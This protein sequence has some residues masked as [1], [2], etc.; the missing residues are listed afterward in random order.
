[1]TRSQT[2]AKAEK[3]ALQGSHESQDSQAILEAYKAEFGVGTLRSSP[4]PGSFPQKSNALFTVVQTPIESSGITL[5]PEQHGEVEVAATDG[6]D[7]LPPSTRP[8]PAAE[9]RSRSAALGQ[10][11]GV[12]LTPQ[13]KQRRL[14]LQEAADDGADINIP[15]NQADSNS[16]EHRELSGPCAPCDAVHIV[17]E[18]VFTRV[19][20]GNP[21]TATAQDEDDAPE[22]PSDVPRPRPIAALA[23]TKKMDFSQQTPTQVN[24]DRDYSE[25]IDLVP[26][27]PIHEHT[28]T[29]SNERTLQ[30]NDT[31]AVDFGLS[32]LAR[33]SSQISEDAGFENTRGDWRVP[34]GTSQQHSSNAYT[35]HRRHGAA[36]ETPALPR[37]PFATTKTT[38]AA[39]LAGSQLFGQT[40]FS[41]AIKKISPT[42]S[43]PSP[44]IF[45]H[46]ISP[47]IAETS[48]LKNRANVSS[49][50]DI[51]TSSPQRL[52]EVL[53]TSS[54][55]RDA[56][57]GEE[58]KTPLNSRSTGVDVIPESPPSSGR[59][60]RAPAPRSSG[61]N[62]PLAHYEPMKKSQERKT[63]G[64]SLVLN[65]E[66]DSDDDDAVRRMERRKQVDRRRAKAAEEMERVSFLPKARQDSSDPPR[67][68]RR[69]VMSDVT[70][71]A[72]RN[73]FDLSKAESIPP[74]VGDSQKGL[75]PSNETLPETLSVQSTKATP[76]DSADAT[77]EVD[78]EGDITMEV[79]LA[80][81]HVEEE[82]I[83]AT[84][85][86]PSLP[87]TATPDEPPVEEPELPS[88]IMEEEEPG[89]SLTK[90]SEPSS[91]PLVRRKNA[92]TYGRAS[93]QRRLKPF[94]SSSYSDIVS[95]EGASKSD[96][97]SSPLRETVAVPAYQEQSAEGVPSQGK[98]DEHGQ[99]STPQG[100][101]AS[102]RSS[103]PELPPPMTTRSRRNEASPTTPLIT[104]SHGP[105]I[106]TS[107]SLSILSTTPN[108]SAKTTPGTQASPVSERPESVNLPSPG[109]GKG[110]RKRA[111]R[112]GAKSESP[113]PVTRAARMA[114]RAP[115]LGSDSTD[116]LHHSPSASALEKSMV[117]SKASRS[118]RQSL[119]PALRTCRLFEGMVFAIS[120]QNR[121]KPLERTKLETKI[122]QAG[123]TILGEGFQEMF[124]H[125]PIMSTA[126]PVIDQEDALQLTK[127]SAQCGFTAL[128]ADSHSRKAKY[129][130]ALAL[131]LPCLAHQWITACLT[132]A[133]IVD[134]QP[135]VLC[136]G[137]S[138]VLGNAIRSRTLP[139]YSAADARL[140]EVIDQRPRLLDGQRVLVVVDSR[141]ARSEAKEPYIFLATVL[142][143]SISRVFSTQQA[144][145]ALLRHQE[146]GSP[147]D[148]LYIDKGTG[149]VEAVLTPPA[150][151]PAG[152]AKKR[153]RT[154]AAQPEPTMG[155]IRVLDDEL[156][157]QSLIL[158]RMVE[159][160]EMVF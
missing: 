52:H 140:A 120:F 57:L 67:R 125:S 37:N 50:T 141:K 51:R 124:E 88:L 6:A 84:S 77:E 8:S 30:H 22:R 20:H 138:A 86:V 155:N 81:A 147:F 119:A 56:E 150:T 145:E 108:L 97:V 136:A 146:A 36:F 32:E 74:I 21:R 14:Q 113:Q 71:N 160:D 114:R 96:R 76:G 102:P 157:I 92:K 41:S 73:E 152:G 66:L 83:P 101:R 19:G 5:L 42:S 78:R 31:G 135:Y 1:M 48:P 90:E 60:P 27:S 105:L 68:K 69:R 158:G 72:I 40:Q 106:P 115:H 93:R 133:A 91:L 137:A 34:D 87:L 130:Q 54:R 10:V 15:V 25:Y 156:V 131:G 99:D 3:R 75:V 63:N 58:A 149:T 43:R 95:G 26:S 13:K 64:E 154:A 23:L 70:T 4:P 122:T 117:H 134:W 79:D 18:A 17:Q 127:T 39:P 132:R 44:N 46:S 47:N 139:A 11:T 148:W 110:L 24:S 29:T 126:N 7:A 9:A 144:R 129:M 121:V 123:G 16:L 98:P 94:P 103:R 28:Q 159:E 49:P 33:P 12:A 111:T 104:R 62:G 109:G 61:N 59:T 143:P 53:D 107:S 100:S 151:V 45:H 142:G 89:S 153:R 55:G 2:L 38:I 82:M 35:P 65:L 128:I 85:P 80:R 116:E 112:S 118:F